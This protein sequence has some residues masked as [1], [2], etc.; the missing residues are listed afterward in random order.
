MER[1]TV[2]LH[3]ISFTEN[4]EFRCQIDIFAFDIEFYVVQ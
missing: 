4:I 3:D 2:G 1:K